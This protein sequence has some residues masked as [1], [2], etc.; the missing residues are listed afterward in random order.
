M[1]P[2]ERPS[3][4]LLNS[5][6]DGSE[7]AAEAI[8]ERYVARLTRLARTRLSAKL[9]RRFDPED[10]VLSAYR[11]FFLSA[12]EGRFSLKRSGD[13]WRLLVRITLHKLYRT[14]AHHRAQRRS[15][16]LERIGDSGTVFAV[17]A[18]GGEPTPDEAVALAD[19]LDV[20]MRDL[21]PLARRVLELRLQGYRLAEIASDV[22]RT[23]R[24]VRRVLAQIR[25]RLQARAGLE[26]GPTATDGES[27]QEDSQS[28]PIRPSA[29]LS[30]LAAKLF[31][32]HGE[33]RIDDYLLQQH[34]G[35]GASGKVYRALERPTGRTVAVKYLRK[36]V[37]SQASI[38]RRF[39]EEADVVARLN[40]PGIVATYGF[41]RTP[42]G[43]F[44]LV[45]EFIDGPNLAVEWGDS[46]LPPA[47]RWQTAA[48]WIAEAADAVHHAH[49]RDVV[50]CDL[51]PANLLLG[52][53]GHIRVTDFGL[54]RRTDAAERDSGAIAGTLGFMAP[55]QVDPCWGAI[56]PHT[57]IYGLGAVLFALLTG[58]PPVAGTTVADVLT[59]IVVGT[60][61]P[62][63]CTIRSDIPTRL[64]SVVSRALAK[65]PQERFQSA[66]VLCKSLLQVVNDDE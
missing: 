56:R 49:Q 39:V 35:T 63:V 3:E 60:P 7:S 42:I 45:Q 15:V 44:F 29:E 28:A 23:E 6:R 11:S 31:E 8:F 57:D 10:V 51:K 41:G 50:H 59:N 19:E 38:V 5:F 13:L 26:T 62:P 14:A 16:D 12:R 58:R 9:A 4:E 52:S 61:V 53:D 64:T 20:L 65:H 17:A 37:L 1:T 21:D 33:L 27:D 46:E 24:T 43:G 36:D 54:A 25:T 66:A 30:R 55:E 47:R 18:S 22:D 32:R 40:H 48:S 2:T 34:L